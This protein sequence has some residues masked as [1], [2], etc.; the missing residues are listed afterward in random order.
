MTRQLALAAG[1]AWLAGCGGNTTTGPT[2]TP[3]SSAVVLVGAGDIA[4]CDDLTAAEAT[5]KLLDA[6]SGAV[7]TTGDNVYY[8]GTLEN[9]RRC[10]DPTWGRHVTR[11]RPTPGNHEYSEPG[12]AGYFAYFGSNAGPADLGY[13]SYDLGAWHIIALNNYVPAGPGSAQLDWLAGDLSDNPAP[14]ILAYWHHPLFSSG[15]NGPG[16]KMQDVWRLLYAHG[17]EI[18]LNGHDHLYER[19]GLQDP[20]GRPDPTRGIRQFTVGTGGAPLYPFVRISPNSEV[21]ASFYG[22]LKLALGAG[23]YSWE[24]MSIAGQSFHD[25]GTGTCH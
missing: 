3:P 19:F 6:T 20:D 1:M 10:Y 7:Y 2:P 16:P 13:Y 4:L 14:C 11:T 15:P 22:V 23:A 24:F 21:R 17:V 9:F 18:V 12:A 8:T 25:A 5:A